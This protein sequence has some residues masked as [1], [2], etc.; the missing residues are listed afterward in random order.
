[1]ATFKFKPASSLP[2]LG[3]KFVLNFPPWYMALEDTQLYSFD[4]PFTCE[5]PNIA[6]GLE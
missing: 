5:S 4:E 1:L 3:G 6:T 2:E